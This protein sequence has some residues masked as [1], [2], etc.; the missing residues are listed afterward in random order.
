[1]AT[2]G[3]Q[4][5][6]YSSQVQYI[7]KDYDPNFEATFFNSLVAHVCD[8]GRPDL[9]A[10]LYQTCLTEMRLNM[11]DGGIMIS[12]NFFARNVK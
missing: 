12:M 1:M 2:A 4:W 8:L 10:S 9:P 5:N 11:L 6:A 7:L 3:K